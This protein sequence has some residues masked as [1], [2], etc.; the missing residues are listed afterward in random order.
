[1]RTIGQYE[2]IEVV[3]RGG[4]GDVFRARDPRFDRTVAVKVLQQHFANDAEIVARFKAEAVVQAKLN[5]PGI[6]TVLDFVADGP[7]LAIVMEFIH[8]ETLDVVISREGSPGIPQERAVRLFLQILSAVEFAHQNGLVHRDLKPGNIMI[9]RFGT[10]EVAKVMDFGGAKIFGG[11]K[12]RTATAAKIGTL[13]YMSPEHIESPRRVDARSD[14]YSLGVILYEAITGR[15]PL[16][17]DTEYALMR[18][19]VQDTPDLTLLGDSRVTQPIAIALS[20]N[21]AE[22]FSTCDEFASALQSLTASPSPQAHRIASP[23]L[24][25]PAEPPSETPRKSKLRPAMISALLVGSLASVIGWFA[26][27]RPGHHSQLPAINPPAVVRREPGSAAMAPASTIAPPSAMPPESSAPARKRP[28]EKKTYHAA[29]AS[30][31]D[32]QI[33]AATIMTLRKKIADAM[34]TA[35]A[36]IAGGNFDPARKTIRELVLEASPYKSQLVNELADMQVLQNQIDDAEVAAKVAAESR[37]MAADAWKRRL[38]DIQALID[39][40]KLPEAKT[41][42]QQVINAPEAPPDVIASARGLDQ[43]ADEAL[44]NIFKNTT[45]KPATSAIKKPH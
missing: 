23:L 14:I 3:G 33:R 13:A 45:F 42:A 5:H 39:S 30:T 16:D 26:I 7:D 28:T 44:Q 12:F 27:K 18:R 35:R 1:M 11:E 43:R 29:E 38:S 22:R 37:Q 34:Q 31:V 17:A 25:P 6:A 21:P 19:I 8:G 32:A 4:M 40:G 24:P 10:T 36:D 41:L 15:L 2:L 20:K 9:Q